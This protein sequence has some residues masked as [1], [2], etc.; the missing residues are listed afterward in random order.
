MPVLAV[1]AGKVAAG[2]SKG[3]RK[4]SG[5]KVEERLL[6]NRI[7]L[8]SGSPSVDEGIEFPVSIF[9][10]PTSS[11]IAREDGAVMGTISAANDFI[12]QFLVEQSLFHWLYFTALAPHLKRLSGK[13]KLMEKLRP[14]ISVPHHLEALASDLKDRVPPIYIN[15]ITEGDLDEAMRFVSNPFGPLDYRHGDPLAWEYLTQIK[16]LQEKPFFQELQEAAREH[17]SRGYESPICIYQAFLLTVYALPDLAELKRKYEEKGAFATGEDIKEMLDDLGNCILTDGEAK[18]VFFSNLVNTV[19]DVSPSWDERKEV[20]EFLRKQAADKK[21]FLIGD[22][23]CGVGEWSR[24]F[25]EQLGDAATIFASD[26]QYHGE[27]PHYK[28]APERRLAFFRANFMNVPLPDK[29]LDCALLV[30][31][32]SVVTKDAVAR[33]LREIERVLK[34]DSFLIV[35]PIDKK[36][37]WE[38]G[39]TVLRKKT[40]VLVESEAEF[41]S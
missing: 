41:I 11:P 31:V 24:K 26:Q 3:E 6:L 38:R 5:K 29:S 22:F 19:P 8:A 15:N 28:W 12:F 20:V 4:S 14:E 21:N 25:K 2:G 35:G 23:G 36:D 27:V 40:G 17:L 32:T 37:S 1:F 10:N 18:R 33:G 13:I 30:Y 39:W 7:D 34:D 16:N 9:S